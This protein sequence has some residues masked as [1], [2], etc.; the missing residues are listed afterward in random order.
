MNWVTDK[1]PT[2]FGRYLIHVDYKY[3]IDNV[4]HTIFIGVWDEFSKS[5]SWRDRGM[6]YSDDENYRVLAWMTLPDAPYLEN[7]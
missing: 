7:T 2:K 1:L 4:G 3:D 5:W 6:M